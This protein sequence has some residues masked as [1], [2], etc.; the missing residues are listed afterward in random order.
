[1][2]SCEGMYTIGWVSSSQLEPSVL[3]ISSG[4]SRPVELWM[5]STW[6]IGRRKSAWTFLLMC[7]YHLLL[8]FIPD[9]SFIDNIQYPQWAAHVHEIYV[10]SI[11]LTSLQER[12]QQGRANMGPTA[13]QNV[14]INTGFMHINSNIKTIQYS[15]VQSLPVGCTAAFFPAFFGSCQHQPIPQRVG[16]GDHAATVQLKQIERKE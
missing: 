13:T 12:K 8:I 4:S 1:M 9:D 15:R 6:A 3:H 2:R 16:A 5:S 10:G 7:Q 14:Y 11:L